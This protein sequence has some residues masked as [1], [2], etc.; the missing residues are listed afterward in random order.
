[1]QSYHIIHC[2]CTVVLLKNL[3]IAEGFSLRSQANTSSFRDNFVR[4]V[5]FIKTAK[6]SIN[7]VKTA[8]NPSN[9]QSAF[10]CKGD[11]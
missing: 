2:H 10:D 9:G 5:S 3:T 8:K 1:M 4:R 7:F 6:R 11:S